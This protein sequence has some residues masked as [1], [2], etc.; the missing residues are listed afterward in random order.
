MGNRTA[1][2]EGCLWDPVRRR[3]VCPR[4][5]CHGHQQRDSRYRIREGGREVHCYKGHPFL[6][7]SW[8][9]ASLYVLSSS[10]IYPL[11]NLITSMAALPT[12]MGLPPKT[13]LTLF[14]DILSSNIASVAEFEAWT[15]AIATLRAWVVIRSEEKE[16]KLQE[17]E[18]M[19]IVSSSFALST[20]LYPLLF[21]F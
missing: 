10:F 5:L 16:K 15:F 6:P 11:Y 8:P 2:K 4:P 14:L 12:A 19:A 18:L 20:L 3:W 21:S 13:R 9:Q 1:D 7:P 17:W